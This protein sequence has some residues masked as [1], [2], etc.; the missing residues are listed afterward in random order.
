M[1]NP[2]ELVRID[3]HRPGTISDLSCLDLVGPAEIDGPR[4]KC[5][6]FTRMF[7]QSYNTNLVSE[8]YLQSALHRSGLD[9]MLTLGKITSVDL[10][11]VGAAGD[12]AT[13]EM[14]GLAGKTR[15]PNGS[16]CAIAAHSAR[17]DRSYNPLNGDH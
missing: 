3:D 7:Y 9:A 4:T 16:H 11:V 13:L 10:A 14:T 1:R 8:F 6:D 15:W 17:P 12:S 5:Y 2:L